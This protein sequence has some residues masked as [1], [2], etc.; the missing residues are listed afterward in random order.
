MQKGVSQKQRNAVATTPFELTEHA[1]F[2]AYLAR[3]VVLLLTID[4]VFDKGSYLQSRPRPVE[5]RRG[6]EHNEL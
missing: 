3:P 4:P 5:E 6:E 2:F 1:V